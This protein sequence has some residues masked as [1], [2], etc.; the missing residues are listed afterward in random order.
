MTKNEFLAQLQKALQGNLSD[1]KV[2]ENID[3][4]KQY[5]Q[6]EAAKG[7]QEE[8]I[9]QMLGDPW[10]LART[11]IDANDGTDRETVYEAESGKRYKASEEYGEQNRGAGAYGSGAGIW[12]K[13]L[14]LIMTVVM[15]L[16]LIVAI[17]RG[18]V[19]L[20]A[21]F[22]VPI[23]IVMLIVRIFGGRRS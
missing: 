11:I 19:S 23:L 9:L 10:I 15:V 4:Y 6:E 20:L 3:Y 2:Q 18:V 1:S 21:P 14:L 12:W 7:K 17:V 8:D 5:I 16:L 13:K 22:I